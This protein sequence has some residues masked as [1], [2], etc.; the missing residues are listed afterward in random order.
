[1]KKLKT[2][3]M[4]L[5]MLVS[6]KLSVAQ[7]NY[8]TTPPYKFNMTTSTPTSTALS[9]GLSA[10]SV[11]NGAY[12]D[13]GNLLFYIQNKGIY[14]S[15]GTNVGYL[16]SYTCSTPYVDGFASTQ[17]EIVPIP[18]VCNQFYVLYSKHIVMG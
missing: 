7:M 5:I 17:V 1:M 6:L 12:D 14:N 8:W 9:G 4:F 18:D 3:L 10:Y 15:A 13:S 11:A 16:I 2:A